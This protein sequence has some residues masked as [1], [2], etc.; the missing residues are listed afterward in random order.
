[1]Q[2]FFFILYNFYKALQNKKFI[3]IELLD[4]KIIKKNKFYIKY[5]ESYKTA[6]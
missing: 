2:S 4:A 6:I 5:L 3:Q 1:M